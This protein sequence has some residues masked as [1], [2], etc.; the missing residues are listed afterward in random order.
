MIKKW[1]HTGL[2]VVLA[3]LLVFGS[4]PKEYI[5]LFADHEDTTHCNNDHREGLSF[6]S[7][8]HH[9]TFLSFTLPPFV[10]D[11]VS[12]QIRFAPVYT[13]RHYA[14]AVSSLAA[15]NVPAPY[16]RGPPAA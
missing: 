4:T 8:H 15:R 16:L 9:C 12:Y 6:E 2:I 1:L 11:A 13:E 3:V 5:H 10:H 7:Q 14:E